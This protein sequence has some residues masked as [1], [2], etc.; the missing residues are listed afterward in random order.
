MAFRMPRC[1]W[2]GFLVALLLAGGAAAAKEQ[3]SE[4]QARFDRETN[5]AHKAKL[6][7]KLGDAQFEQIREAE[8]DGNYAAVVK[9][10][11]SYRDNVRAAIAALKQEHPNAEKESGGYR[12]VQIHVREKAREVGQI[13]LAAP[14]GARDPMAALQKELER[15]NEELLQLL[16]PRRPNNPPPV[17]QNPKGEQEYSL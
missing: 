15:I 7:T 6:L 2:C 10:L 16:F 14:E 17:P 5:S 4:L 13:V 1:A 3:V 9:K 11:E 12:R 8:R